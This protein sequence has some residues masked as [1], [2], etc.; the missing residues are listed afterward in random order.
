MAEILRGLGHSVIGS[1]VDESDVSLRY[2]PLSNAV[3]QSLDKWWLSL[4]E[5]DAGS[6]PYTTESAV[7]QI[8]VW[9]DQ[10]LTTHVS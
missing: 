3:E 8:L 7:G 1:N 4:P 5:L 2:I 9:E 6:S 10:L